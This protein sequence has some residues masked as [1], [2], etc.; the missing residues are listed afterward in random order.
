VNK[1]GAEDVWN[2]VPKYFSD[3]RDEMA[4]TTN[5]LTAFFRS[6]RLILGKE[7]FCREHEFIDSF[8]F[9]CK[10]VGYDKQRWNNQYLLGPFSN[11][12]V[13]MDRG[14]RN[15]VVGSFIIG[16]S[17]NKNYKAD[18]EA[19]AKAAAEA[20]AG[21]AAFREDDSDN[22]KDKDDDKKSKKKLVKKPESKT[23]RIEDDDVMEETD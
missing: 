15:G 23:E 8:N 4:E 5:A 9:Y 20:A 21:S 17:I 3:S 11:F 6:G 19:A 1:Y 22:D 18:M 12:D 7:E 13:R 14:R 2:I 16:C 10:E